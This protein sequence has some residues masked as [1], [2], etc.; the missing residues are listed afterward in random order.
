MEKNLVIIEKNCGIKPINHELLVVEND[1]NYVF[2]ND[3]NFATLRLY[4]SEGNIINVNSWIECAT[5]VNGGWSTTNISFD[6]DFIFFLISASLLTFYFVKKI[7][8][9]KS[10]F[11]SK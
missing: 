8:W 3:P 6:G 2:V 4:D 5:Y 9:N 1:P 11:F 7:V 10:E